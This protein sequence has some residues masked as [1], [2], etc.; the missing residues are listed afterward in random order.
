[1]TR[2]GSAF[3]SL[4]APMLVCAQA[5]GEGAAARQ[6]DACSLLS[7]AEISTAIGVTVDGGSRHDEGLQ[8]DGSYSSTCMWVI[9][10]NRKLPIPGSGHRFVIL[11]AIQWP[12]G[13]DLARTYLQ[14]FHNAAANGEIPRK[15][16][17]RRF[18]DEA[19]WWGD[20]LAVRK[21]DVSFGVSVFMPRANAPRTSVLEER[22]APYILRKV[23]RRSAGSAV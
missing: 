16:K 17:P 7:S 2:T 4:L 6:L 3:L 10:E 23:D 19:L 15:P 13:R 8:P 1:M 9:A 18:G 14:A 5:A 21:G 22:L 20:G 11:S 12:Q